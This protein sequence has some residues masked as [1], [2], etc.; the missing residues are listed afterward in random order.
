M[1]DLRGGTPEEYRGEARHPADMAQRLEDQAD[2]FAAPGG[3]AVEADV[4]RGLQ[5][6][7]LRSGLRRNCGSE[8]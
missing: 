3:T 2:R 5:K 1:G 4:S 6:R 7:G 8:R